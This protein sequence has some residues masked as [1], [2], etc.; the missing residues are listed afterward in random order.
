VTAIDAPTLVGA[1]VVRTDGRLANTSIVWLPETGPSDVYVK[2]HP[3]PFGEFVPFRSVLERFI[4]RLDR[5]PRDFVAGTDPGVLQLGP[6]KAAVVICFEIAEDSVVSEHVAGGGQ[7]IAVQTNN[8]TY[9]RTG[10]PDQ[11][12]E[13]SRL[14]A[15]EHSREVAIA[16]TS[17]ISGVIAPNGDVKV[18][19]EEFTQAT[20]STDLALSNALTPATRYARGVEIALAVWGLVGTGILILWRRRTSGA[21]TEGSA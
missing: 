16:A 12:L 11:Q 13:I 8:A 10:Q 2:R 1:V 4:S 5:V 6:A 20:L 14:R 7:F 21:T 17:G 19:T 18:R 9:G 15:M 3:V